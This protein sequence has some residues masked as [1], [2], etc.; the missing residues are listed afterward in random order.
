[1]GRPRKP[2]DAFAGM[3]TRP[4]D[5]GQVLHAALLAYASDSF[6]MDMVFRILPDQPRPGEVQGFS[7]DHA[8]PRPM[9]FDDWHLYTQEAVSL[10]GNRGLARGAIYHSDRRL[11]AT[12]AQEGLVRT[13]E[14][15]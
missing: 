1:M 12:V 7:V 5:E 8:F 3:L 2:I 15:R 9:R 11:V 13:L 4:V 6:L 10:F 14:D